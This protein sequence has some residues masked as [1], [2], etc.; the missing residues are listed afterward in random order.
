[1]ATRKASRLGG[2]RRERRRH[3]LRR[4]LRSASLSLTFPFHLRDPAG[5]NAR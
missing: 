2:L 3:P 5:P 1:V 4:C